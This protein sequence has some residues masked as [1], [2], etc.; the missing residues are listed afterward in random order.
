MIGVTEVEQDRGPDRHHHRCQQNDIIQLDQRNQNP[1]GKAADD[2]SNQNATA[3]ERIS[4]FNF[5]NIKQLIRRDR[6]VEII[7]D[8]NRFDPEPHQKH[9]DRWDAHFPVKKRL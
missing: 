4:P 3:D 1:Q 6:R 2:I 8:I 9:G 7:Q 5:A